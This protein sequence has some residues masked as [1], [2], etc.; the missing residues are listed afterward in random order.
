MTKENTP[1]DTDD[2]ALTF[3]AEQLF[4]SRVWACVN[5]CI[6]VKL[7]KWPVL[8]TL[9]SARSDVKMTQFMDLEMCFVCVV[10]LI[11]YRVPVSGLIPSWDLAI[12]DTWSNNWLKARVCRTAAL[13]TLLLTV[14]RLAGVTLY[15]QHTPPW[16]LT[17]W[18]T[19]VIRQDIGG[20]WWDE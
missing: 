18:L 7:F 6:C 16:Q 11:Q 10:G 4:F 14:V 19:R 15:R 1:T 13:M 17:Q 12:P 9:T 20:R 2:K 8:S 5:A 3:H